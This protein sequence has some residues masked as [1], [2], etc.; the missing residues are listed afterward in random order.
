MACREVGPI[1]T[2]SETESLPIRL[3]RNCQWNRCEFCPV[4]KSTAYEQ[5][6]IEEILND[7]TISQA[8]QEVLGRQYERAFFQDADPIALPASGLIRI[9]RKIKEVYPKI[10]KITSYGRSYSLGR[11]SLE[12]L[13]ELREYGLTGIYRGL[14]SGYDP[15]LRYMKKG[16][17]ARR[18]IESGLRVKQAGIELSDFVMPGLGGN[19]ELEGQETWRRH[20][21][22]T[23]RVIN[24]TSPDC[25]RLRTLFIHP[26]TPLWEKA[27]KGEFKRASNQD[28]VKEIRLF[29]GKLDGISSAIESNFISN[30]VLFEGKIP[31]DK[32]KIF[33][34]IDK[35][36]ESPLKRD[37]EYRLRIKLF[38]RQY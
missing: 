36:L 33:G 26:S 14:E 18:L 23:A 16:T 37:R 20:A 38:S 28:I 21:E 4:Y 31:E 22:E 9:L 8:M 10:T 11:K 13:K 7:I 29:I 30:I 15:L 17:T 27:K 3:T 2:P 12:E 25:I 32:E 34:L 19:L 35:Y 1:I 6:P 24:A 5:R